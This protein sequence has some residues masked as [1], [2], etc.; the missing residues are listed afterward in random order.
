[1]S[2]RLL[3]A[4]IILTVLTAAAV[5]ALFYNSSLSADESTEQSSPL[6]SS[7]NMI[8]SS[9]GLPVVLTEHVVRKL[10][11]FTEYAVMGALL[12]VT[13]YL[14]RLD[15]KKM[16]LTALPIGAVIPVCDELIQMASPGRSCQVTDMLI[17][18]GGVLSA[19]LVVA[20]IVGLRKKAAGAEGNQ[21]SA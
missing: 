6:T 1:M 21:T 9:I 2:R 15:V 17:D 4:R 11:H 13:V 5:I 10:A 20:L 14:Y 7:I 18:F 16:L 12:S 3:T 8:L 19:A